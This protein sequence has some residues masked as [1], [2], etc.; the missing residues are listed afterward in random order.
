[1]RIY[2]N[3]L[4]ELFKYHRFYAVAEGLRLFY[5]P[6]WKYESKIFYRWE[7]ENGFN[8][9]KLIKAF[10]NKGEVTEILRSYIVFMIVD[11]ELNTSRNSI[12]GGQ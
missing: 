5:G 3:A 7:I 1:V 2:N 8:F 10:F 6:T 11:E 12:R 4:P 9:E